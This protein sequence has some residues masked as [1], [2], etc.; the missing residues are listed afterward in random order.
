MLLFACRDHDVVSFS[1]GLLKYR[2]L[3]DDVPVYRPLP[4]V[5]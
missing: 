2:A 3:I 1:G 5:R 4:F